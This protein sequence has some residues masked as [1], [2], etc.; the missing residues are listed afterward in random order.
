VTP[1]AVAPP[2]ESGLFII[3]GQKGLS[4]YLLVFTDRRLIV[5]LVSGGLTRLATAGALRM[6]Y[7]SYKIKKMKGKEIEELLSDK[8]TY[9][10]PYGEI[11]RIEVEKGGAL[12]AGL[13]K[14]NKTVGEPEKFNVRIKNRI[15][16]FERLLKPVLGGRLV[17]ER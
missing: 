6:A 12:K 8:K 3:D 14:V 16:D 10:I 2:E 11:S 1:V 7:E 9:A 15:N 5:A 17:I 4:R 13:I